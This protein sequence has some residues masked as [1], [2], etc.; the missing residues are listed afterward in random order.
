VSVVRVQGVVWAPNSRFRAILDTGSSGTIRNIG[1]DSLE[2]SATANMGT[3]TTTAA[4]STLAVSSRVFLRSTGSAGWCDV[5][6]PD[7]TVQTVMDVIT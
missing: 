1:P 3:P 7:G 2:S 4:G 5:S 6:V